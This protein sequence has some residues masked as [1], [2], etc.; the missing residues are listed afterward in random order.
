M[1]CK[2]EY[3][4]SMQVDQDEVVFHKDILHIYSQWQMK[5]LAINGLTH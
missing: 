1:H 2:L 5:W 3:L 4:L